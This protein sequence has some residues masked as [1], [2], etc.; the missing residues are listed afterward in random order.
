MYLSYRL[1]FSPS[2]KINF[3]S[4]KIITIRTIID[5]IELFF[6]PCILPECFSFCLEAYYV[7][8]SPINQNCFFSADD[9]L[10]SQG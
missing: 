6:L 9:A 1:N 7:I 8:E 2:L 4:K 5:L 3:A 10:N